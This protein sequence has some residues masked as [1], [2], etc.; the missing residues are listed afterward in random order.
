MGPQSFLFVMQF[1]LGPNR[2]V[3]E[4]IKRLAES[5]V[6]ALVPPL[7]SQGTPAIRE[8]PV[9]DGADPRDKLGLGRSAKGVESLRCRRQGFL[10]D[11]GN[12][13]PFLRAV[14]D[15]IRD[16]PMDHAPQPFANRTDP[17]VP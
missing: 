11:I 12:H 9:G 4:R 2:I 14:I 1:L 7:P 13:L 5:A 6:P 3:G 8:L 10:S 16:M 15:L 17:L